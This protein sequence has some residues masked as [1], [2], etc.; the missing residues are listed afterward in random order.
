VF[1]ST[2]GTQDD[3]ER[4]TEGLK[5]LAEYPEA[6]LAM[7]QV[8][9]LLA[10]KRTALSMFRTA[11]V[12]LVFSISLISAIA[13]IESSYGTEHFLLFALAIGLMVYSVIEMVRSYRRVGL[14]DARVREIIGTLPPLKNTI[15]DLLDEL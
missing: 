9:V 10:E 13:V 15:G 12:I 6:Q 8:Q 7:S 1:P 2:V 5:G 4:L 14:I 11:M 3:E